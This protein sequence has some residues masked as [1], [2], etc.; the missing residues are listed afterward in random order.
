VLKIYKDENGNYYCGEYQLNFKFI[1]QHFKTG[2]RI[3]ILD[4]SDNTNARTKD[5]YPKFAGRINKL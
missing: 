3:V 2:D 4:A 1:E 5:I